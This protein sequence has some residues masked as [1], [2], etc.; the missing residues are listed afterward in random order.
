MIHPVAIMAGKPWR[1]FSLAETRLGR[2]AILHGIACL[3][4]D[5]RGAPSHIREQHIIVRK[6]LL[7]WVHRVPLT[8]RRELPLFPDQR[9]S[10]IRCFGSEKCHFRT[11]ATRPSVCPLGAERLV[12][13]AELAVWP[14]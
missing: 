3:L 2:A 13:L 9:T 12:L 14:H 6:R 7:L 11:L 5:A 10:P 8:A 4:E 1:Q